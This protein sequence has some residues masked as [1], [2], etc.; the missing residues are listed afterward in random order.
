VSD[1]DD[2]RVTTFRIDLRSAPAAHMV[3]VPLTFGTLGSPLGSWF[4][5][6]PADPDE[7]RATGST[8]RE[9]WSSFCTSAVV[10]GAQLH[11]PGAT[12]TRVFGGELPTDDSSD[13]RV[14]AAW[15]CTI[16]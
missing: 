8:I 4:S 7:L 3:D 1:G 10:T 11:V 14:R 6:A 5:A 12:V 16:S 2:N 15:A 13:R 9:S